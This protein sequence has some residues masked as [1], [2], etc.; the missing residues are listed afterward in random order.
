MICL[1]KTIDEYRETGIVRHIAVRVGKGDAVICDAYRGGIDETT[2]FD[3]ASVTKI[4]VTTP[5]ASL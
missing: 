4:M 5:L 3:M 1:N 2:C